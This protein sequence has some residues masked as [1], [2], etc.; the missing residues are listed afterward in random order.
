MKYDE[1]I[2]VLNNPCPQIKA[3]FLSRLTYFWATPLLWKGFRQP[4]TTDDLWDM[5]PVVTSRGNYFKTLISRYF[6]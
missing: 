6:F 2:K 5:D 3:S 1:R 4:L